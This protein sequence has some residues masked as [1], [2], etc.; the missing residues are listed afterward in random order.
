MMSHDIYTKRRQHLSL[1]LD[2]LFRET[3]M[4]KPRDFDSDLKLLEQK[5][6]DLKERKVRAL[7]ELVVATGADALGLD[8]LAGALLGAVT[9]TDASTREA[10]SRGG[11]RFFRDRTGGDQRQV[12]D[13][14]GSAP[15]PA[16]SPS[17]P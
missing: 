4:R 9:T 11:A 1:Y 6:R 13:A 7:G 16:R 3:L 5:A 14:V 8:L 12:V 10:W 15:P 2:P 17:S